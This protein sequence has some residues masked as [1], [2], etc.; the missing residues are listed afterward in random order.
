MLVK[1]CGMREAENIHAIESLKIDFMGF[2]FYPKSPRYVKEKPD[3]LPV[4]CQRVGVFVNASKEEILNRA[5][6]FDLDFVQLHGQESPAQCTGLKA[7]GLQVIKAFPIGQDYDW[8]N[9]YM[10]K[11]V[12]DYFLFDTAGPSHGGSG[13]R[14]DWKILKDYSGDTPFLL[15]GGIRPESLNDVLAFRHPQFR[16]VDLNSGFETSPG[17]KDVGLLNEFINNIKKESL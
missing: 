6:D 9:T 10:Y 1:V 2:I 17:V 7:E 3:Y 4:H 8:K 16:G 11:G 12:A 5:K 13:K 15:S 14:F